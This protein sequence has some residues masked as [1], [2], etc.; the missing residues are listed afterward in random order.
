MTVDSARAKLQEFSSSLREACEVLEP[1][2]LLS[3]SQF[4][5]EYQSLNAEQK[6]KID[7]TLA[8]VASGLFF[9][10]LRTQGVDSK[11]HPVM[12]EIE[13]VKV[14]SKKVNDHLSGGGEVQEK[15]KA[16]AQPKKR[17]GR[18]SRLSVDSDAAYRIV[19]FHTGTPK[20][21]TEAR[22]GPGQF[23]DRS[24][25]E[26]EENKDE[27]MGGQEQVEFEDSS[28]E[29]EVQNEREPAFSSRRKESGQSRETERGRAHSSKSR[30]PAAVEG[31]A[32]KG[33]G[34]PAAAAAAGGPPLPMHSS[35]ER[36]RRRTKER[37]ASGP[38]RATASSSGKEA[39]KNK[40][41]SSSSSRQPDARAPEKGKKKENKSGS[42]SSAR[43]KSRQAPIV[44]DD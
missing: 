33:K 35:A 31:R 5:E 18:P 25:E 14:Y 24:E 12:K 36:D 10:A 7:S 30:D 20:T 34:L 2:L 41:S 6:M 11:N 26:E 21:D 4:K 22:A 37:E 1:V 8:I 44:I 15:D 40:A 16:K 19:K 29:K 3:P 38:R 42:S 23:E 9:M 43:G 13:R 27:Q 17:G 32:A 39:K 28:E